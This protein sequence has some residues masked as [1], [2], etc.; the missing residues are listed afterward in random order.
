MI[1]DGKA[2]AMVV[3]KNDGNSHLEFAESKNT[4]AI[5]VQHNGIT[6]TYKK[7]F[8]EYIEKFNKEKNYKI[9]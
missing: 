2:Y 1:S 5:M 8:L 4:N 3:F 7:K 9:T 6:Y